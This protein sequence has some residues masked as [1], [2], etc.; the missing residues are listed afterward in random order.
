LKRPGCG[1]REQDKAKH[2]QAE[3]KR[4]LNLEKEISPQY[5]HR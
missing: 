3:K 4:A 1:P 5:L 2:Q